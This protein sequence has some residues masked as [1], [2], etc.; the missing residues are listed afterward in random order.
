MLLRAFAATA[1][2]FFATGPAFSQVDPEPKT[3]YLWRI[4]LKIEPHPLL[5]SAFREQ[6]KRDL[7]AALQ[8]GLGIPGTQ[9][10]LGMVDVVDLADTPK[11]KWEPLWQQFDD[12]GFAALDGS[13]D[14]N[15][16]KTHFLKLE[17]RDGLYY[18]ESRQHDGFAGLASPL[19]RKQ[20]VRAPELVGR[21]AGLML[22]RDFGLTGSIEPSPVKV[23]EVKVVVRGGQLGSLEHFVK[24]GDIFAVS[25]VRK[26]NRPAPPP[27]RT[28]TGKIIAPPPGSIPPPGL[29][30]SPRPF[31]LL[32]V[33]DVYRD[34]TLRC[35][36][37]SQ[38]EKAVPIKTDVPAYRCMRLGTVEAPLAVRLVSESP[39]S[40][41][42]ASAVTVR[43]T[44]GGFN[45]AADVRDMLHFQNGLFRSG[46]DLKNVA[47]ITVSLAGKTSIF[48]VPVLGTDTVTLPFEVN[49]K[50]E[51]QAAHLRGLLAV[52]SRLVDARNAQ[53]ICFEE[54][55]KAIEKKKNADALARAKGGW[56][57]ADATDKYITDELNRLNDFA[58]K[59]P[60]AP[61]LIKGIEQN[62]QA[63]RTFNAELAKHVKTL[64]DVVAREN[65]PKLAAEQVQAEAIRARIVLLLTRG[66][67]DEALNAYDLLL[68]VVRDNA[69]VKAAR[70][71]LK[72][73]WTPK[74][75]AHARARDYLL[76]TWPAISTIPDFTESL[77][78]IGPAI[79]LCMKPEINDRY[80]LRK[81][82]MNFTSAGVKLND[83]AAPLDKNSDAD[84]KLIADAAK[85]GETMAAL[86]IKIT[87]FLKKGGE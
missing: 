71:K 49:P 34:G 23:D 74:N 73:E 58:E 9:G 31:T 6:L 75:D 46:R 42:G 30:A 86:E 19:V 78:Q 17:Y 24:P 66:D 29:T 2:L 37:L 35:G 10:S 65:D 76:K 33:I 82:L 57:A 44:E 7:I 69:E 61:K 28:S 3:P 15:G 47:C 85:V 81:L 43:A 54:T 16:A 21:T 48:P 64:E 25:E 70:D 52:A 87:E 62:L 53:T 22:D 84:R 1:A 8:P 36:V 83:L 41:G 27:V 11:D 77:K 5:S 4:V 32:R 50:L 59:T 39:S 80:T 26:T 18:L 56:Q 79:D 51:E 20:S 40:S 72:A 45:V 60:L 38:Y 12:K 68:Q 55:A 13:R 14:L 63:L 67:V